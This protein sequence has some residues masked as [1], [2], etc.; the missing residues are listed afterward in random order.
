MSKGGGEGLEERESGD[1]ISNPTGHEPS[2]P[3]VHFAALGVDLDHGVTRCKW[4]LAETELLCVC[5]CG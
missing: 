2:T 4:G 1:V 5:V 3:Q